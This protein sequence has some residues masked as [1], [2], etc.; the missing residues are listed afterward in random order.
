MTTVTSLEKR[1]SN[2][3]IKLCSALK[4][5]NPDD[6]GHR[7]PDALIRSYYDEWASTARAV[8][9]KFGKSWYPEVQKPMPP[10]PP[11]DDEHRA[12]RYFWSVAI[13][14]SALGENQNTRALGEAIHYAESTMAWYKHKDCACELNG[15]VSPGAVKMI[16]NHK[17]NAALASAGYMTISGLRV[18]KYAEEQRLA[19]AA[20]AN[21]KTIEERSFW[22]FVKCHGVTASWLAALERDPANDKPLPPCHDTLFGYYTVTQHPDHWA[23]KLELPINPEDIQLVGRVSIVPFTTGYVMGE[24]DFS[25]VTPSIIKMA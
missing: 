24:G 8:D 11:N 13:Q 3:C 19:M 20:T 10:M 5:L 7:V 21:E 14:R 6:R 9:E 12:C 2:D 22:A 25:S 15:W 18:H 23:F 17:K 4:G 1:L 16:N